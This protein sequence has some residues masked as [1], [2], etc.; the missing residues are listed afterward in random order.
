MVTRALASPV[1]PGSWTTSEP[2]VLHDVA[3]VD[4]QRREAKDG[5]ARAIACKVDESAEWVAGAAVVHV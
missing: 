4:G 3:R 2:R 1:H 5:E